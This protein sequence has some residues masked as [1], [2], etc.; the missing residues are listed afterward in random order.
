MVSQ[1]LTS[2]TVKIAYSIAK[3]CL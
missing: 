1:E 2:V 3:N